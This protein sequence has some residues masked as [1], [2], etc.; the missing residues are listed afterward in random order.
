MVEAIGM[1]APKAEYEVLLRQFA[2]GVIVT[3]EEAQDGH[4]IKRV[5]GGVKM[6]SDRKVLSI[7]AYRAQMLHKIVPESVLGLIDAE[8]TTSG[9]TDTV[10]QVGGC[11]SEPLSDMECLLCVLDGGEGGGVGA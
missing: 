6:V 5:G 9:A 2:C 3:L 1:L 7:I 8:E 4:V 10:D 11:I